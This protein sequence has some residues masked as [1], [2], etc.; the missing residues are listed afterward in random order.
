MEREPDRGRQ[1]ETVS[2]WTV[3]SLKEHIEDK[4]KERDLR[5]QQRFEAGERRLDGMNE[6]RGTLSDQSKTFVT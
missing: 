3:D 2:D 4:L 5:F 1:A 6:F